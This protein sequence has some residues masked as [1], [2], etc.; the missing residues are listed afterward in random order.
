MLLTDGGLETDLIF[1]HNIEL[2]HFAA[3]PLV[4]NKAQKNV[5]KNYYKDYLELAKTYQTGFILESP[6]WRAN[7]DWGNELGYSEAQL[8]EVNKEAIAL[9]KELK[10][11]YEKDLSEIHISGQI[12]PKGDGYVVGG[13]M[14][15]DEAAKYHNLQVEAFNSAGADMVTA[16]TMT[17]ID[18]ALGVVLSAQH[19]KIPVVISFTIELDG[20]L[21]SGEGLKEAI[22]AI[23]SKTNSYASYYMINCAHPTHFLDILKDDGKWKNRIKGIRAN[24]ST[25]S[26]EEL[27]ECEELDTGDKQLL[28]QGYE[29]LNKLLPNLKIIGGCCGTDHTHIAHICNHIIN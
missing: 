16:I 23:D 3:F 9:M 15:S 24:A 19:H 26:H 17:Y 18:E 25:M 5:L 12:G 11:Q 4:E 7:L 6:T 28:S 13:T 14:S 8:I 21:P 2:E 20:N 22:E 29:E 10:G 27:D 1:N